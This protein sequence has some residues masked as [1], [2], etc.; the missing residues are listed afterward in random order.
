MLVIKASPLL[1]LP[2]CCCANDDD[3]VDVDGMDKQ[4]RDEEV[5]F[6]AALALCWHTSCETVVATE[7][8]AADILFF[9]F[10]YNRILSLKL[11]LSIFLCARVF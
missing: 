9:L 7:K 1:V 3:D 5:D 2:R 6:F 10:I 8:V 4:Q 11:F